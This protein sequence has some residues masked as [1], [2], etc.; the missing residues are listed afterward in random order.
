[1]REFQRIERN[2]QALSILQILKARHNAITI[3][4]LAM[5]DSH[6]ITISRSR[7]SHPSLAQR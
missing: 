4:M 3:I 1:M 2:L 7:I 6:A 5:I